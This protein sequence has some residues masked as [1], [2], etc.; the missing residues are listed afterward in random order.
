MKKKIFITLTAL[1]CALLSATFILT[2]CSGYADQSVANPQTNF[3]QVVYSN[4]G[5]A[6]QY[7]EYVYFINGYRG[8]ADTDAKQ[9]VYGE[10]VKGGIYRAKL[11]VADTSKLVEDEANI[12]SEG[13]KL[14]DSE[15]L[16]DFEI[17]DKP[18]LKFG[19][20]P[21]LKEVEDDLTAEQLK[22]LKEEVDRVKNVQIA[23][24][25][26]GTSGY[27][28]GGL[29]IYD[30]FI[31]FASPN[32][33]K[34]RNGVVQ[35]THTDFWRMRLNGKDVAKIFTTQGES[36][37]APYGF[38]KWEDSVYLICSYRNDDAKFDIVSV[39]MDDKK[40]QKPI[41]LTQSADSV[42]IP[43]RDTYVNSKCSAAD[44]AKY[45]NLMRIGTEDFVYYTR[46]V[47]ESDAQ[48]Q[49]NCVEVVSPDGSERFSVQMD[50]SSHLTQIEDVRDGLLFYTALN[51]TDATIVKY[52]NLHESFM[53]ERNGSE[54]YRDYEKTQEG[55][56]KER[57]LKAGTVFNQRNFS[58]YQTRY[59][60]SQ[61]PLDSHAYMLGFSASGVFMLST[62]GETS[63]K[64]LSANPEMLFVKGSDL[65]YLQ[66]G[67]IY[68]TNIF[69]SAEEKVA[70]GTY[71]NNAEGE[72]LTD[73]DVI[74]TTFTADLV[75]GHLVFFATV[76]QWTEPGTAYTYVKKLRVGSTSYLVGTMAETDIPLD[77]ELKVYFGITEAAE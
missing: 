59:Y 57:G 19:E 12:K 13:S 25:T 26:I 30:E 68:R 51:A 55:T 72:R 56:G 36:T 29:F 27:K 7:G 39:R 21:D 8:Y 31:Y 70:K 48:R 45:E 47:K 17:Q 50:G 22:E 2:G 63:Y 16:F 43:T 65:Y 41:Y 37:S 18:A 1:V 42:F 33:E 77:E 20:R 15:M 28:K 32:N 62:V 66:S 44:K 3:S 71:A 6:V 64:V 9:N 11:N 52:T 38:Y 69:M 61:N 5:S 67:A 34:D 14:E 54:R 24:K 60:F 49:G 53:D 73:R 76:D 46:A 58:D 23:S 40:I 10:I 74:S 35:T 75:A 4:G